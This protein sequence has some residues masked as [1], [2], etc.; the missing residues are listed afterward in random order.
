MTNL[1]PVTEGFNKF[2][3]PAVLSI[4]TGKSTDECARVISRINGSYNV[5]GVL[6]SD[7]L[8]AA[9]K[10]GFDTINRDSE[11]MSLYRSLVNLANSDGMY[12]ITLEKHF[13]CI[14]VRDKKIYFCDNH[15]K[16]PIPAAS[17]A[18]LMLKVEAVHQVIEREKQPEPPKPVITGSQINISVFKDYD[19]YRVGVNRAITYDID[20]A[21]RSELVASFVVRDMAE[22]K[23]L[24]HGLISRLNV[25]RFDGAE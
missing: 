16:E 14:E 9:D 22:L 21:N 18:R 20:T 24:A 4:M 13:V 7:L 2:C 23:S 3:G 5:T 8:K 10:L 25:I 17:S 12:I 6:L 15:T 11:G 19:G 1:K